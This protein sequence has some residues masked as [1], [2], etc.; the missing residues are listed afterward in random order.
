MHARVRLA[1]A[2]AQ[3]CEQYALHP[4]DQAAAAAHASEC[5][6]N[7]ARLAKRLADGA[8]EC[9]ICLE[10]VLSKRELSGR[11][12]GL[13]PGCDHA[14]CLAC[15]RSWRATGE[16]DKDTVRRA[17]R[18]PACAYAA[19]ARLAAAPGADAGAA[20]CAALQALR[21]CP[22]CRVSSHFVTPSTRWPDSAEE[23]GAIIGAYKARMADKDCA[24]FA[25]G[26]GSCPFGTSCFYK[27]AYRDGRLE[28]R[29]HTCLSAWHACV[30]GCHAL[31]DARLFAAAGRIARRCGCRVHSMTPAVAGGCRRCTCAAPA[32]QM[33][34]SR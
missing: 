11:R 24:H 26:E 14:F 18:W 19:R 20:A 10:R 28:V 23:K 8:I 12:F 15:I 17:R 25:F 9:G 22:V 6:A 13:L 4:Y 31:H 30:R 3:V 21:T 32:P 7:A 5:A 34:A 33:A 2:L 29:A 1:S 27:H 16:V